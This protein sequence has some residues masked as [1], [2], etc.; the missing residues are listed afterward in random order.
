MRIG[1]GALLLLDLCI[2]A[3]DLEAHYSENGIWPAHLAASLGVKPGYWSLHTII[4]EQWW[5]VF[6]FVIHA[7]AA[8]GLMLGYFTRASNLVAWLL[9]ISLHNRNLF[10]LQAGDDLLRL[11]LLWGLFL[12]WHKVLSIDAKKNVIKG[13]HDPLAFPAYLMLTASVYLFSALLKSGAE[14]QSEGTA[15]YYALGLGQLRLPYTGDALYAQPALMK[16]ITFAVYYIEL[17]IP[18]LIVWP[19]RKGVSRLIA[20]ILIVML[21]SGIAL[22]LYVGLFFIIA[23]VTATGI[24]PSFIFRNTPHALEPEEDP[25]S[26][27]ISVITVPITILLASLSLMINFSGL[28]FFSYELRKEPAYISNVLRLD[29]YWGM[30]SPGV[31]KKDGWFVYDGID[32]SGKHCDLRT[33]KETVDYSEPVHIVSMYPT[34]RW[35]K[36]AEN[37]QN[38]NFTFLRALY[39]KYILDEWNRRHPDK[40]MVTLNLYFMQRENGPGYFRSPP[41]KILYCVAQ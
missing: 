26:K 15:V 25:A 41:E 3:S 14:W 38:G 39:A 20:F 9:L 24:L 23:I 21:H 35:R 6:L 34:D 22:T 18:L 37:M 2:R 30:F 28:P 11:T 8:T 1:T 19:S 4:T 27:K 40:H 29:Q 36:L 31:L 12:P 32:A 16:A 13:S 17:I 10:I 7:L 33:G 5:M